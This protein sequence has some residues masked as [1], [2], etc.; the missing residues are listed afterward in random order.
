[1]GHKWEDEE[2]WWTCNLCKYCINKI[3]CPTC[4]SPGMKVWKYMKQGKEALTCEE[5][6]VWE[7]MKL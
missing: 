4:P 2:T 6:Q 3:L 5:M 1:M 7:I